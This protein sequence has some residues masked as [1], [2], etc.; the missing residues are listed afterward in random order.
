MSTPPTNQPNSVAA[1]NAGSNGTG[2]AAPGTTGS[3]VERLLA[4]F[5]QQSG[6]QQQPQPP[7]SDPVREFAIA[8]MQARAAAALEK[9]VKEAVAFLRQPDETKDLPERLA[10]G[11]LHALG[12]ESPEFQAAWQQRQERPGAWKDALTKAQQEWIAEVKKIP[13]SRVRTEVEA[14]AAAVHGQTSTPSVSGKMPPISE[15]QKMSIRQLNELG[16]RQE[17]ERGRKP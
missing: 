6:S 17:A 15:L 14:A 5:D 10:L 12:Q 8:E 16:A 9:D 11:F 7:A 4:E 1:A 3:T 2:A 13:T